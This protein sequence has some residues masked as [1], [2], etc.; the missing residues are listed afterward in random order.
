MSDLRRACLYFYTFLLVNMALACVP[1][2]FGDIT[3]FGAEVMSLE[4]SIVTNYSVSVPLSVRF[5][6]LAVDVNNASFCN[7]TVTYTHQGQHDTV[8]VEAWLPSDGWNGR[9]QAVG[10]GGM[11]AGWTSTLPWPA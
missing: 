7:V 5:T 2:T 11:V 8:I 10:G 3:V 4:A 1:A 9:L 6:Q